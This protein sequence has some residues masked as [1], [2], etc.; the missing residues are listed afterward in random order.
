MKLYSKK[1]KSPIKI[2]VVLTLLAGF[3]FAI[4]KQFLTKKANDIIVAQIG[5]ENIYKSD[6]EKKLKEVF[7]NSQNSKISFEKLSDKVLEL[8]C[9]EI[10]LD[11]KIVTEAKRLGLENSSEI[12][13][14]VENF[15][16][17]TIRQAYLN[18]ALKDLITDQ[19]IVEKFNEMNSEI[20]NKSEYKYSQ[21]VLKDQTKAQNIYKELK[22]AKKPLKFADGAKKYSIDTQSS[23]N[24][25]EL[26]YVKEASLS[27]D[28]LDNLKK[29]KKDEISAP[30]QSGEDWYIVKFHDVKKAKPIEFESA[31]EYIRHLIKIEE[32]EK[33]NGKFIKDHKVKILLKRDAEEA[34]KDSTSDDN[35][36]NNTEDKNQNTEQNKNEETAQPGVPEQ[37]NAKES[38]QQPEQ[39]PVE[40]EQQKL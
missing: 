11:K 13:D 20:E 8:F 19:K 23:L 34:V 4:S 40:Q 5:D 1:R 16:I 22:S 24:G 28:I 36:L 12:K 9:R 17:S 30:F 2:L 35:K 6:I 31:K 25:G 18:D 14:L 38:E 26:E 3:A 29:L 32:I 37:E 7:A 39:Q 33:I 15:K 21:I 27:K 10:F